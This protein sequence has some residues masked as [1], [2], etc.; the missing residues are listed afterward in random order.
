VEAVLE[1]VVPG[2]A[3]E[4]RPPTAEELRATL[5]VRFPI[6]EGSAKI[7]SGGPIEDEADLALPIWGGHIPL[8][9][10]AGAPVGD[11]HLRPGVTA[12]AYASAYRRPT[13]A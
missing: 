1:H 2:R 11:G 8:A 10:V 12:P 13:F 4:A 7:R 5:V 9:T 3:A 6:T